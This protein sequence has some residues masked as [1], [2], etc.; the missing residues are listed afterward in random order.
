[1]LG[2]LAA[3]FL[4]VTLTAP[5]SAD[6]GGIVHV[7]PHPGAGLSDPLLYAEVDLFKDLIEKMRKRTEK[8]KTETINCIPIR[9]RPRPHEACRMV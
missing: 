8:P 2:K 4:L 1:M 6:V 7:I 9:G 3:T 5:A